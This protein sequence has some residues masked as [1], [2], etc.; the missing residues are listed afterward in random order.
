MTAPYG[1]CTE[2][3]AVQ[4]AE[5][6]C[7]NTTDVPCFLDHVAWLNETLAGITTKWKFVAGHHPIDAENMK[8]MEPALKAHG[9]QAYFAGHVHNLQHAVGKD[10]INYFI[11]GAGAF[12]HGR[13]LGAAG[14]AAVGS[15]TTHRS[16]PITHPRGEAWEASWLGDGPG[17]LSVDVNGTVTTARFFVNASVVYEVNI[18]A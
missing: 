15:G 3:C 18:T 17:F 12:V 4:L 6:G 9:V 5:V 13:R 11:S 14:D 7:T 10:G 16:R 1:D 8:L 2:L